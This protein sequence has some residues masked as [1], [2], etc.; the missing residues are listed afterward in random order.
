M[1]TNLFIRCP[2][3]LRIY[4]SFS[5]GHPLVWLPYILHG[6]HKEFLGHRV[7]WETPQVCRHLNIRLIGLCL[8][9]TSARLRVPSWSDTSPGYIRAFTI[10]PVHH[11]LS[12]LCGSSGWALCLSVIPSLVLVTAHSSFKAVCSLTSTLPTIPGAPFSWYPLVPNFYS[13]NYHMVL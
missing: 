7:F 5:L 2:Y 13:S 10:S 1:V 8:L 3:Y 9:G 11:M 12:G 6:S 4:W